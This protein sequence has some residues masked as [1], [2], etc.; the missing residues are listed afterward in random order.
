M[1]F[2]HGS[3][4]VIGICKWLLLITWNRVLWLAQVPCDS[5]GPITAYLYRKPR[6]YEWQTALLILWLHS[7][8]MIPGL[9]KGYG[10][11]I[12]HRSVVLCAS[13]LMKYMYITQAARSKCTVGRQQLVKGLQIP[14]CFMYFWYP[15]LSWCTGVGYIN[16]LLA[17]NPCTFYIKHYVRIYFASK[18]VPPWH[19][20]C[21]AAFHLPLSL[22]PTCQPCY[23]RMTDTAWPASSGRASYNSHPWSCPPCDRCLLDTAD[24]RSE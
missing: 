3:L 15:H 18:F 11:H 24:H 13:C 20:F 1:T 12:C 10:G 22:L 23:S 5:C 8:Q 6:W 16:T 7:N 17:S 19:V 21:R 4:L 14:L 2:I 9:L